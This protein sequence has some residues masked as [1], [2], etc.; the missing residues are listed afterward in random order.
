MSGLWLHHIGVLVSDIAARSE[1]YLRMGYSAR[2]AIIHDPRQT[3]LVRFLSHHRDSTYLELVA[4]DGPTSLLASALRKNAGLHHLCYATDDI[5]ATLAAFRDRSGVVISEP[6]PSVAFC[7]SRIA[8]LLTRDHV[9]LELV[10]GGNNVKLS[11]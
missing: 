3:A 2:T 9:L 5:A 6:T 4:P 11:S 8:W 10:E 1:D 7:N